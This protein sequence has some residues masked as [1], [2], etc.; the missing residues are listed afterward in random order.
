MKTGIIITF[1]NQENKIN[2]QKVINFLKHSKHVHLCLI[3]N[4]STDNTISALEELK[5][6][7]PKNITI[8]NIKNHKGTVAV[9]RIGFRL[10]M[11]IEKI[12]SLGYSSELNE[13]KLEALCDL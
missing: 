2:K 1:Y 12:N 5:E 13:N 4:G 3:N 10:L 11:K 9:L 8:G 6:A 7:F